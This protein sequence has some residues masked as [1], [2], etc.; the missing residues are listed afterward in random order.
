MRGGSP[1]ACRTFRFEDW[2]EYGVYGV[3]GVYLEHGMT[4]ED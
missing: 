2:G 1:C 4:L 3:Y